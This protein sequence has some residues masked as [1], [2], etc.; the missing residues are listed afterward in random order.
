MAKNIQDLSGALKEF[1]E[2]MQSKNDA[3]DD[4]IEQREQIRNA[5][6]NQ[7]D[8]LSRMENIIT[9][10]SVRYLKTHNNDMQKLTSSKEFDDI[11][12][13]STTIR[14]EGKSKSVF[15]PDA[16]VFFNRES[17]LVAACSISKEI[18]LSNAGLPFNERE[19]KI[20]DL[21]E[22]ISMLED[23][24]QSLHTQAAEAGLTVTEEYAVL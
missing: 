1:Q 22:E 4:L 24:K 18:T 15:D 17:L 19:K 8:I 5:P 23:E 12:L 21:N 20:A 7:V 2:Q 10:M 16:L 6:A 11:N 14:V 9:A 3:I 13:F